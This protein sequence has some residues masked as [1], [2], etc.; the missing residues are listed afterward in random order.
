MIMSAVIL[1]LSV[2]TFAAAFLPALRASAVDPAVT[3]RVDG[4]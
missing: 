1:V 2:V 4:G 3:L